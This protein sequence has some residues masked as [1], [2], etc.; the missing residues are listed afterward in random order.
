MRTHAAAWTSRFI[1]ARAGNTPCNS[2]IAAWTVHPRP[3]GEHAVVLEGVQPETIPACAGNTSRA[4]QMRLTVHP[5]PRGE[6]APPLPCRGAADSRFI[7]ARAGNTRRIEDIDSTIC[8]SVH[9]RPRGEHNLTIAATAGSVRLRG[10]HPACRFIPA[11]A[12][13][14]SALARSEG[15]VRF[16]RPAQHMT[17]T[18]RF[19]P[20]R[21]GNTT[22]TR[23]P[24]RCR[25]FGSSP[26][27]RGTH[28]VRRLKGFLHRFIPARAGNTIAWLRA[29]VRPCD[30]GS[31]PPA[32][33]TPP[34]VR[35]ASRAGN[36]SHSGSSPPARG[37]PAMHGRPARP[38]P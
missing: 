7:P 29:V 31:S 18:R 9:P 17:T 21:A 34:C 32:R 13:N 2:T 23:K 5:R 27:A 38:W 3:R 25:G 4:S 1:P 14:T 30:N 28:F 26:P 15:Y 16:T 12:G 19:I 8:S 33:G 36:T 35:V 22:R 10:E 37:T 20:A 24:S 11:R 6:H